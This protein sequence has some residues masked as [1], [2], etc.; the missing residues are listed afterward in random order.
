MSSRFA[1]VRRILPD[2][3]RHSTST[4]SAQSNLGSLRLS[5]FIQSNYRQPYE[6]NLAAPL[7]PFALQALR[8]PPKK[9]HTAVVCLK[10]PQYK[11]DSEYHFSEFGTVPS[12]ERMS[13]WIRVA[14]D[15]L[16]WLPRRMGGWRGVLL[17][18]GFLVVVGYLFPVA[19]GLD[20]IS[21]Q[22]LLVYACSGPF[23]LS[24]VVVESLCDPRETESPRATLAGRLVT[25]TLFG[26][27]SAALLLTLALATVNLSVWQGSLLVPEAR[28][29]AGILV[30]GLSLALLASG[31]AAVLCLY[32]REPVRV[33]AILRRGY[34]FTL[35][36][37]IL[38]VRYGEVEWQATLSSLLA[39]DSIVRLAV[40]GSAIL[41]LLAG[42]MIL[43][44]ARHPRN[45]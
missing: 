41:L 16:R 45:R 19:L 38:L 32:V 24:S 31:A 26:W 29:L 25:A 11:P 18:I 7:K 20:F 21:A 30:L 42:G 27:L 36:G 34:V 3:S 14:G 28:F 9:C 44:A 8:R 33:K 4:K 15:E 43:T 22:I 12:Y 37:A 23:F 17:Y 13:P 10:T 40:A 39:P 6:T 2:L 5:C 1:T 35:I